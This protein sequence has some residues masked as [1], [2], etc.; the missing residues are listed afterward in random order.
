[1]KSHLQN[2]MQRSKWAI[3]FSLVQSLQ[4]HCA[5]P[6]ISI[7]QNSLMHSSMFGVCAYVS[8]SHS[9]SVYHHKWPR[10]LLSVSFRLYIDHT[11]NLW[12]LNTPYLLHIDCVHC[13]YLNNVHLPNPKNF[14]WSIDFKAR[15]LNWFNRRLYGVIGTMTSSTSSKKTVTT[16]ATT[17]PAVK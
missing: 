2:Q 7:V 6:P 1:M 9:I 5:P 10:F 17:V 8:F 12:M 13:A 4:N 14:H 16:M 15:T 11:F 3:T